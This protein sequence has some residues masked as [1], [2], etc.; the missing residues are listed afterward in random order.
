MKTI[1]S[2]KPKADKIHTCD[3]CKED[4]EIGEVYDSQTN[5]SEEDLIYV[6]RCHTKCDEIANKLNMYNYGCDGGLDTDTFMMLI[7]EAYDEVTNKAKQ[8]FKERLKTVCSR[9]LNK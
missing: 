9:Y 4:I 3:Y 2:S 7:D 6:W 8:E 5:K 1:S